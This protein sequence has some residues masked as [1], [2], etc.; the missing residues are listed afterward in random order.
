MSKPSLLKLEPDWMPFEVIFDLDVKEKEIAEFHEK[1]VAPD[2]WSDNIRAQKLMQEISRRKE[3]IDS[4]QRL[5]QRPDDAETLIELAEDATDESHVME[6]EGEIALVEKG[7]A[8]LE[9]KNM[10]S[11]EDDPKNALLT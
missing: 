7:I 3:W 10:L 8:E 9:F 2:F 5:K 1:T 11:E 6:V 4:W